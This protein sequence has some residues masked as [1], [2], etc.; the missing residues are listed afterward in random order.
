MTTWQPE[1]IRFDPDYWSSDRARSPINISA[2]SPSRH[3]WWQMASW[4]S[5]CL[6]IVIMRVERERERG[7]LCTFLKQKWHKWS[8]T[9]FHWTTQFIFVTLVWS[10][11]R[12]DMSTFETAMPWLAWSL[13]SG[14]GRGRDKTGQWGDVITSVGWGWRT[15]T[16][17]IGG[18]N[19]CPLGTLRGKPSQ[20]FFPDASNKS[21][22]FSCHIVNG[23]S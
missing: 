13:H 11:M 19:R 5:R 21:S 8:L 2:I 20:S 12:K 9:S 16:K 10:A 7:V 14:A 1:Q 4:R 15:K 3:R 22:A 17:T 23:M 6:L 18:E